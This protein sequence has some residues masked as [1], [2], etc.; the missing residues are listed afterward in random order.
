MY[1]E[2]IFLQNTILGMQKISLLFT[3][4]GLLQSMRV[5][6]VLFNCF[7]TNVLHAIKKTPITN[8]YNQRSTANKFHV[9]PIGSC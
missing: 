8:T 2:H 4:Y 5:N 3:F 7:I 1:T 9:Y 6:K